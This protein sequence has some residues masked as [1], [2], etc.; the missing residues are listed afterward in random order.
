MEEL[1]EYK[2][3]AGLASTEDVGRF[4]AIAARILDKGVD[5]LRTLEVVPKELADVRLAPRTASGTRNPE[6]LAR[7]GALEAQV[8]ELK[9]LIKY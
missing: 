7:I 9:A 6:N 5:G 3:R 8:A 1:A 4:A 2:M